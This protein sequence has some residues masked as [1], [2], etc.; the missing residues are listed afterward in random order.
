MSASL[1]ERFNEGYAGLWFLSAMRT[2]YERGVLHAL[3]SGTAL[4][5]EALR[6]RSGLGPDVLRGLL[7]YLASVGA[8]QRRVHHQSVHFID[9]AGRPDVL[10]HA[11]PLD[12]EPAELA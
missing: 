9:V 7:D 12:R 11:D 2:A 5:E 3:A 10:P 1:G 8:V 6:E 4:D